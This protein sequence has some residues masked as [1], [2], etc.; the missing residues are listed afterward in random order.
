MEITKKTIN[1]LHK[2]FRRRAESAIV[3]QLA[4]EN[5]L[6]AKDALNKYYTSKVCAASNDD[7]EEILYLAPQVL[8]KML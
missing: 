1:A 6:S 7:M 5:D 4:K 2:T 3:E 8:V